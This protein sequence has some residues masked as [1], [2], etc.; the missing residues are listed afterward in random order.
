M[1]KKYNRAKTH[2]LTM[3]MKELDDEK[4]GFVLVFLIP[5]NCGS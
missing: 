4:D 5:Q 1:T 2:T 3:K